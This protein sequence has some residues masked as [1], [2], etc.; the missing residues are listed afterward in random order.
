M[1]FENWEYNESKLPKEAEAKAELIEALKIKFRQE[2]DTSEA[3]QQWLQEFDK[4]SIER[5]VNHYVEYKISIINYSDLF[6]RRAEQVPELKYRDK[7]EAVLSMILEKKLFNLQCQWRAELITLPGIRITWDFWYW[8]DNILNCPFIDPVTETELELLQ[9]YVQTND[10]E[11]EYFELRASDWQDY[12]QLK[13]Q[14]E[15]NDFDE[16]VMPWYNYYD[17]YMGTG[18]LKLLP[19]VRGPKE[20]LYMDAYRKKQQE[21][22]EAAGKVTPPYVYT[23]PKESLW[24]SVHRFYEMARVFDDPYF[25]TLMKAKSEEDSAGDTLE[26]KEGEANRYVHLLKNIPDL[27][28][29]RGGLSWRQALRYCYEDYLKSILVRDLPTVCEEYNLYRSMGINYQTGKYVD[30]TLAEYSISNHC[31]EMILTGRVLLGEPEDL[32][33]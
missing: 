33:F 9:R 30:K 26:D 8:E 11:A 5:F 13:R 6:I 32:D 23:P 2:I 29:V 28:P 21:E 18:M 27:P 12:K 14:E 15:E 7:T 3:A 31:I 16:Q 4:G 20:K 22:L 1:N 19:D 17:T 24:Y 25:T 10:F